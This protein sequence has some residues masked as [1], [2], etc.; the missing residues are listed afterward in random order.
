MITRGNKGCFYYHLLPRV[1]TPFRTSKEPY[2]MIV[3]MF[4]ELRRDVSVAAS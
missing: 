3:R 4:L 1:T 2:L